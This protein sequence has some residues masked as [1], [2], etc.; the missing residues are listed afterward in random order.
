LIGGGFFFVPDESAQT[1]AKPQLCHLI[2]HPQLEVAPTSQDVLRRRNI[3]A[4][5]PLF[6]AVRSQSVFDVFGI[7]D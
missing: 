2:R 7:R 6:G 5:D 1:A 4:L 3:D